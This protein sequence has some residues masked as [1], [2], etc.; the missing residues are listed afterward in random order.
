MAGNDVGPENAALA[1]LQ[2]KSS[3][4]SAF[5]G[6]WPAA[7]SDVPPEAMICPCG[8]GKPGNMYSVRNLLKFPAGMQALSGRKKFHDLGINFPMMGKVFFWSFSF[9]QHLASLLIRRLKRS[10]Q[11]GV[12]QE[13]SC[14]HLMPFSLVSSETGLERLV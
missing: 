14:R 7:V 12:Q 8:A 9:R 6:L 13:S 1:I 10:F 2:K 11:E 4:A 3:Q 5:A